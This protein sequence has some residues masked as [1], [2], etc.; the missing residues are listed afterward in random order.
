[1]LDENVR[2]EPEMC[3]RFQSSMRIGHTL[4]AVIE[5]G[6]VIENDPEDVRG[7]S[8]LLHGRENKG[9]NIHVVCSPKKDDLAITTA[10]LRSQ[11]E[12]ERDLRTRKT[13]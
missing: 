10:Y 1:M 12:W 11:E 3:A 5:Q 7:H 9:G 13:S 2:N 4:I 8:C 6:D